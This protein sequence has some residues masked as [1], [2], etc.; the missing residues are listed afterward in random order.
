[1]R[2]KFSVGFHNASSDGAVI[3]AGAP[4]IYS[5]GI[6]GGTRNYD[7]TV[8]GSGTY[9]YY[10]EA[11][12]TP[13]GGG[14]A[15]QFTA[16][17]PLPVT[18][19]SFNVT[20]SD[21]N[22]PIV[23]WTT[24]IEKNVL[25]FSIRSST[26]GK[27]FVETGRINAKGNS[28]NEQQYSFT[29]NNVSNKFRYIFYELVTVDRDGL[30]A[31]SS[32]KTLKTTFAASRLIMQFGPNPIKRPGQLMVQFNAEKE[33]TMQ[34]NVFDAAGKKALQTSLSA[35][36]GLNNG[37]VHVCDLAPGIYTLQFS[38]EGLVETKRL[39]VN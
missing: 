27:D 7:Y 32:I 5:G 11:H 6:S 19:K 2:F 34:V 26:N 17:V 12:G 38:N 37:H 3:P 9:H 24:A 23:Q 15:G 30:L 31:Y 18:L 33:G 16:S 29:D 39:V 13:D 4:A 28:I 1:M 21:A 36:P 20:L 10:C 35:F 8:T 22:K 14:M 25:Y